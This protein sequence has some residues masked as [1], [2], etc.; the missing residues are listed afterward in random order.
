MIH[1]VILLQLIVTVSPGTYLVKN[2]ESHSCI[3]ESQLKKRESLKLKM[4]GPLH[5]CSSRQYSEDR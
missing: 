1:P 4:L 2:H 3:N 5:V